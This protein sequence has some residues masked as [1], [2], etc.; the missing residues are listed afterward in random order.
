MVVVSIAPKRYSHKLIDETREFVINVPTM[1]IVKETLYCGRVSG[2]KRDKFK[3]TG[4]TQLPAKKVKAPIIKECIAH[5]ECKLIK[6]IKTGDHT[7]FIGEVVAAYVNEGTFTKT[8][9]LK[10]VKPIYH[11]GEDKF[12]TVESE[13]VVLTSNIA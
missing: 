7:L 1:K 9:D 11:V 12:V 8:Y 5:L 3:D 13:T 4:L 10:R 6:Q 2:R